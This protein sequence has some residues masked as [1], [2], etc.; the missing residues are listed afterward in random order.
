MC[1]SREFKHD[2]TNRAWWTG[3][4][5]LTGIFSRLLYIHSP[6]MTIRVRSRP[7]IRRLLPAGTRV[8][9]QDCR[10]DSIQCRL[11]MWPLP[12]LLP[13]HPLPRPWS[14]HHALDH[15]L[16]AY[17]QYSPSCAETDSTRPATCSLAATLKAD[18]LA[19]LFLQAACTSK[20]DC[21]ELQYPLLRRLCL[22]RRPHRTSPLQWTPMVHALT[23]R[24]IY[25][26]CRSY[27][28]I[29]SIFLRVQF[30][31]GVSRINR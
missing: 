20:K 17:S 30:V 25:R 5:E 18:S 22:F 31:R 1:L 10:D 13:R 15:A 11:P 14:R 28:V 21:R 9:R 16:Y 6:V 29:R 24:F 2:E 12:P 4:C 23:L 3:R 27:S 8:R 19:D 7:R 26:C